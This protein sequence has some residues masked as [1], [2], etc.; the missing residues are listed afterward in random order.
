MLLRVAPT[1]AQKLN[2]KN[3]SVDD[4]LPQSQI[5]DVM[6][7]HEGVMWLATNGGGVSKYDGTKFTTLTTKEGLNNNHVFTVFEDSKKRIW[8]G[9]AKGLNKYENKVLTSYNDSLVNLVTVHAIQEH[10]DGTIWIGTNKGIIIFDGKTFKKFAFNHELGNF[11]VWSINEDGMGNTW[12][13][14]LMNGVFCFDG[15]KIRHFGIDEGLNDLKNRDLLI[16]DGKLY[17]ATYRGVNVLNISKPIIGDGKQFD[18]LKVNGKPY[19]ETTHRFFKDNRGVLWIGNNAGVTKI[20]NNKAT[21]IT[22]KNG[23]CN[24]IIDAIT[25]D[26]EG[27]MWLGSFGGGLSRYRNNLFINLNEQHG[28]TN[29]NVMSFLKDKKDNLWVATW[30]GGVSKLDYKTFKL[31]DTAFFKNFIQQK[32]G[33]ASNTIYGMCEDKNGDIWFATSVSGVSRYDGVKFTNYD[34]RNG[35]DGLRNQAI[36]ADKKG[37]IWIGSEAG[38]DKWDGEKFTLYG[39]QNGFSAQGVS[40]IYEDDLGNLWFGSSDKIVKFDGRIF[41]TI[42]RTEGFPHIKNILKDRYGYM[43]FSTDAGIIVYNGKLFGTITENDG[44]V[45]N[46]ANFIQADKEG[47][48]WIGTNKGIDKLDLTSY[49]DQ[50]EINLKHYGKEE[51]F[52]AVEC[53]QNSFY[54]AE[55]GR[56]WIGTTNGIMIYNPKLEDK[57]ST[58]EPQ[59]QITG[60]RLFLETVDLSSYSDSLVNGLPVNFSLPYNKNHVT[61]DFIGISQTDPGNVRYKFKLEGEDSD[62]SPETHETNATY[63]NLP[64]GKYTFILKAKNSDGVWNSKPLS[65]S[66][67]IIS[68]IWKRPWFYLSLILLGISAIYMTIK[69][70]ERRMRYSQK[71]LERQV[72]FRTKELFEEKEKLQIVYSEI[73]EK[74]KS[75]T[76]SIHYA[77][78]IQ[79]ALLPTDALM[80][81][82]FPDSFVFFR[83]KDIVSGDF[84]WMEQWG[85]QTLIAS[86]DCTGHG[87]PGAFMSIVGHNILSH[88][89]NVLGLTKPS[90]ILNETNKQLSR[91]LNQNPDEDTVRD[92]MDIA[93]CAINYTKNTMEFAGANNPVWIVRNN[94]VIEINGDKFPIGVF[95]GEELQKFTNHEWEL[96]KGDYIYI[97]SD[98]YADQ[99]GGPKGKKFKYKEFQKMLLDNHKKPMVEQKKILETRFDE[100]RGSLEQV[101]DVLVIG[102]RV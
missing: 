60:I 99:F 46:T 6:Q 102:I 52:F 14:T 37:N 98:G 33:L 97:F 27:N 7:D 1:Q 2:I 48:L 89:V 26:N 29:D 39:R 50:K 3:Y 96:Q 71:L 100:W 4:G 93:L 57:K 10:Q 82:M 43:W 20:E 18:T 22:K 78:R 73:D 45:S 8:I 90:L 77:K 47:N 87:V 11:Q 67:E 76:D 81:Q 80:L 40:T 5:F 53:N 35:L 86:A 70:R 83:P 36:L 66:F 63:S 9:T 65:F 95:V 41:T 42:I 28:L 72:T 31:K 88:A 54:A 64:P 79:R 19:L 58:I 94:E 68:P 69:I 15:K 75:I 84:Y 13:A 85:H 74:N 51:G 21:L 91:K 24:S 32:D 92:G 56:L 17:V 49:I 62:W 16:S 101:D 23:L 38:V 59:T 25:Q 44:L 12:I 61:F 30:G 55:D 34:I